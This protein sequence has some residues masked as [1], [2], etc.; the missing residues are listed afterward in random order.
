MLGKPKPDLFE[1][2][3][4]KRADQLPQEESSAE[5]ALKAYARMKL[6]AHKRNER[7]T[8]GKVEW[9]PQ[10]GD[11]VLVKRQTASEGSAGIIAK[12]TQM[13]TEPMKVTKLMPPAAYKVA[14]QNGKIRGVFHK[15][16]LKPYLLAD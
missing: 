1:K 12:F 16:A 6:K 11:L 7:R 13:Y 8:K 14:E 3:L 2:I 5:K 4:K 15:E 9:N 10:L